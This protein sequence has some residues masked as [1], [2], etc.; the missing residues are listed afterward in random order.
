VSF[1]KNKTDEETKSINRILI[2]SEDR[3]RRKKEKNIDTSI[4]STCTSGKHN[5]TH[6]QKSID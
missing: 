5:K 6:A 4:Y 3:E 2:Y 1:D